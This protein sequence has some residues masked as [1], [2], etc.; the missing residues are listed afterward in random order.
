MKCKFL[1]LLASV[2]CVGLQSQARAGPLTFTSIS[3]T[4]NV[5]DRF[6]VGDNLNGLTYADED[7][8]WG[9]TLFYS[10]RHDNAGAS[11]F[12]TISA[13][14]AAI[15][16][17]GI[18]TKSY[19]ALTFAAPD[20]GYGPVI[21]YYLRHDNVGASTFG[22]ITPAGAVTD[23]FGVGNNF[24]ALT[25][26]A[27]DVG[28]GANLFYYLRRDNSGIAT[29]GTINPALPG[30][31]TDRFGVG[32]DFDALV[33]TSTDVGFGANLFYYLRHDNTG[34]STF[35]TISP[36][37]TV[38]DRFGLGDRFQELTFTTT[39]VKFGPNLFYS[40][41]VPE[42]GTFLLLGFGLVGLFASRKRGISVA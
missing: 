31:I 24:N 5:T 3:P 37:G 8:G 6:D 12:T 7:E 29:F 41:R 21:F 32:N 40:L 25:F 9:P 34:L 18:G 17:F 11:T 20:V 16:R 36:T 15:G 19:D 22:T 30:T 14:G 13:T 39:D 26:S 27:G 35:G 2:A 1:V 4:G 38:T 42:P 28:Y 10:I 23:R 33:F